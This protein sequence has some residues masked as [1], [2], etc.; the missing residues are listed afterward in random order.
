MNLGKYIL[1]SALSV[2]L[3]SI[4]TG[5]SLFGSEEDTVIALPSPIVENQFSIKPLWSNSLSSSKEIY[6][7]LSPAYSGNTIYV[8]DRFG[9][10]KAI[11]NSAGK[12]LWNTNLAKSSLFSSQSALLSGGVSVDDKFVYVGSERAVVYAL[13]IATGKLVWQQNVKGEV[14]T[15][16]LSA[17]NKIIVHTTNGFLQ[18]L[19]RETGKEVWDMALDTPLLS[20]RGQSAPVIAYGAIIV[21]DDTGHVNAYFLNDGQLIWQQRISQPSGSTEI[22]KL[23]DVDIQPIIENG[24]VYAVGYNGNLVALDLSNG[25]IIWRKALSTTHS[26]V[27]DSNKIYAIDQDDNIF[28]LFKNG[29]STIWKQSEL[30]H[31]QLTDPVLYGKYIVVGDFE[32]YLYWITQ[33]DGHIAAKTQVNSSGIQATPLVVNNNIIVQTK[34]GNVYAYTLN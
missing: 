27:L 33:E 30:L 23:N 8:A 5:C 14:L 25:Q 10:V 26:F 11:D 17:E 32:G 19:D 4:T 21:G 20:L 15:N 9:N 2:A 7:Q 28:S 12:T 1:A 13:E 18:A 34:N 3:V 22:A 24:L 6:S 29:G 31:R 16:P